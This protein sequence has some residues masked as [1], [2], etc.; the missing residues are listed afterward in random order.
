MFLLKPDERES[1]ENMRTDY[2]QQLR[3]HLEPEVSSI[4][5]KTKSITANTQH[6]SS[7]RANGA[8]KTKQD[9][10]RNQPTLDSIGT[11]DTT[12]LM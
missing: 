12:A 6:N 1:I 7:V 11:S 2:Y 8:P 3:K 4:Q 10:L 9:L 5:S